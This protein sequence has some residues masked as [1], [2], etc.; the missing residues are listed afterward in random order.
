V[1]WSLYK[2]DPSFQWYRSEGRWNYEQIATRTR[3]ANGTVDIEADRPARV[4]APV[5]WGTYQLEVASAD[6]GAL[7]ASVKFEAGWYVEPKAIDTPEALK[8]SLDKPRY[9]VGETA[10]VHLETRFGGVALV[11]V[12]DDR[13]VTTKSVEVVGTSADVELPVTRDWGPGAYVTAFLYRPMDLEAK[14]MP[15]RAVGLAWA[16]VDPGNRDLD[17]LVEAPAEMRPRGLMDVGVRLANAVPGDRAF[18]T[19]AAVDV[20]I[21]NLTRYETPDPEAYYFGQRRLGVAIRDMYNQ[22]IDRCRARAGSCAPAATAVSPA[23][24]APR[25]RKRSSPSIPGSWRS[26]PDGAARISVP[27]PDFNGTVRLM[28]MAWTREG[29]GPRGTRRACARSGGR[30]RRPATL[31][32]AGRPLRLSLDLAAVDAVR[33]RSLCRSAPSTA[34]VAVDPAFANLNVD[35]AGGERKQLWCR[36]R[37][38]MSAIPGS[39]WG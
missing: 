4:E 15:A 6:A 21:L 32:C 5:E 24:T 3:V 18:V 38:S 16:G 28:A 20:G 13:L 23:S 27:V 29:V 36:S 9:A 12:V 37:A 10:R 7:P 11:T 8:V 19:L 31:P 1:N 39:S 35:V 30:H 26:A 25:R 34:P 17:V 22:L 33:A 2:V 14:R